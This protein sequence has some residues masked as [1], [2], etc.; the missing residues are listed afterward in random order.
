[1]LLIMQPRGGIMT[2]FFDGDGAQRS[3]ADGRRRA[4]R[5]LG[6]RRAIGVLGAALVLLS[7]VLDAGAQ[8]LAVE[9]DGTYDGNTVSL[10]LLD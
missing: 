2:I 8:G 4:F 3:S 1:M 5:W 7:T 9:I 6:G 10:P